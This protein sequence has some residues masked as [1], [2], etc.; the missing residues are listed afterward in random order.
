MIEIPV[1]IRTAGY[2][3]IL[4]HPGTKKPVE[5][6]SRSN[7]EHDDEPV[8]SWTEK[9]HK[10]DEKDRDTGEIT[11]YEGF[12][13]Y[14]L[15]CTTTEIILE[16]DTPQMTT[17]GLNHPVISKTLSQVSGSGRGRHFYLK[18]DAGWTIPLSHPTELDKTG[19]PLNV[20]HVK[21]AGSYCVGPGSIHPSS[22]IYT[23]KNHHPIQYISFKELLEIL[24]EYIKDK[25]NPQEKIK[26][27]Q[28]SKSSDLTAYFGLS[29]DMF[30]PIGKITRSGSE[31]IGSSRWHDSTSGTNYRV[32][33]SKGTWYC[34]RHK[35]GGALE[36][37]AVEKGIISC[38]DVKTGCLEGHWAEIFAVREADGWE[39]P[40]IDDGVDTS[41]L[42]KSGEVKNLSEEEIDQMKSDN[43]DKIFDLS[44]I[45]DKENILIKWDKFGCGTQDSYREYHFA[46]MLVVTS[47]LF[48][49]E[50]RPQYA[51]RGVSN[52]MWC[53]ILGNSG[54]GKSMACGA[55][56]SILLDERIAP[57]VSRISNKFTPESMTM[58][59]SEN[60]R[61]FHYSNEAAGFLKFMKRD[62]AN[63][64]SDDITNGYDGERVSKQTIKM[65]TIFCEHPLF[66]ALWNTTI[67]AWGKYATPDQF[68]SGAFLRPFFVIST[69]KKEVMPDMEMSQEMKA[70]REEVI[71]EI[72][73]LLKLVKERKIVFGESKIIN[74]WKY[75]LRVK[76]QGPTYRE[77]ERSALQRVFDQSRKLAMNMTISSKEFR[78]FL[79]NEPEYKGNVPE[80]MHDI[81][82]K[83]PDNIAKIACDIAENIF[84]KN[85]IKALKLTYGAAGNYGKVMKALEDEG[86]LTRTQIGDLVGLHGKKLDEFL[87]DEMPI[88]SERLNMPGIC[89]PITVYSLI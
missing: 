20:G 74:D 86:K 40:V 47:H 61:R 67:D 15:L 39:K 29:M 46:S 36:A 53:I 56:N 64:L 38:E 49:A 12:G 59:L 84:W 14:A 28:S 76:S 30:P 45:T 73:E 82:Y 25:E 77:M 51:D 22:G 4:L 50:M 60:R 44:V 88:K 89:K 68:A 17:I 32:N 58:S 55:A 43:E 13:N 87:L 33:L 72:G 42:L 81:L 18:T 37:Y 80:K 35:G 19:K 23:L 31:I 75:N 16:V 65:G 79:K 8:R 78:D 7:Y 41:I 69:R 6:W 63:E 83:I 71:S 57:Y 21:S 27:I 5:R 66:S 48:P 26:Y 52:N 54:C 9:N 3:F 24:S 10:Y 85:S 1:E 62:Y 70:L 2:R 11:H 34:A